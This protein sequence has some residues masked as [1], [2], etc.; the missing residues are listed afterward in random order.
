MRADS[1]VGVLICEYGDGG[2]VDDEATCGTH[3]G[4]LVDNNCCSLY[5]GRLAD[6]DGCIVAMELC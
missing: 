4:R 1:F 2:I 3:G 6:D 5:G